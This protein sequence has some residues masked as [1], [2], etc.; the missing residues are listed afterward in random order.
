M[1]GTVLNNLGAAHKIKKNWPQAEDYLHQS[2][3][4]NRAVVGDSAAVLAFTYFHLGG[5]LHAQAQ[6]DSARYYAEQSQVLA[7]KHGLKDLQEEIRALLESIEEV[8]KK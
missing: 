3:Q 5:V 8:T 2:I 1:I 4:H 6:P 7:Q